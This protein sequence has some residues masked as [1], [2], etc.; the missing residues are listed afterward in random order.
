MKKMLAMV[1]TVCL[2]ATMIV[3]CGNTEETASTETTASVQTTETESATSTEKIE[4]EDWEEEPVEVTWMMW[5]VGGQHSE[6]GVQAV[7][8]A[9]NEITLE[10]I[11][12]K[13]NLEMLDM[14]TYMTQMP[15][16][17][18]AGDKIDLITTF[19]AASGRY[20]TMVNN[21]QLLPLDDLLEVY[22]QDMLA[23]MP[24]DYCNATTF[25]GSVY[26]VPI[27]TDNTSDLYW[28]CKEPYLEE[29]GMSIEDIKN[30]EDMGEVFEKLHE[31][32]PEL[33][34]LTGAGQSLIG[35]AGTLF[36]GTNY[37]PMGTNFL[38]VEQDENG[39]YIVKNLFETENYKK[40]IEVLNDWYAKGYVDKDA[41]MNETPEPDN[42]T[43]F[44]WF[45]AGNKTRTHRGEEGYSDK[46][47]V[48][49]KLTDGLIGTSNMTIMTMA[50]PV[51]ATEPEAA[52]KLMNLCYTNSELKMLVSYGIEG[53][54]YT[55]AE[56]GGVVV[57][58]ENTSYQVNTIGTF[59]N[60]LLC[61]PTEANVAMDYDMRKI[62]QSALLYSPLLGFTINNDAVA[63][64]FG[65][66]SA[67][68]EE[69]KATVECGMASEENY[70]EMID[71][72]YANGLQIYID[73]VQRQLDAWMAH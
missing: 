21:G 8:D 58:Q 52:A 32:H 14:G 48:R 4:T 17:I 43:W 34:L 41:M 53:E 28:I 38:T 19:P 56:N 5:N 30:F 15:I 2:M 45:L 24:Q 16:Q 39:N 51:S 44:S 40:C 20:E 12:V 69:Y 55:I 63:N 72:M 65:A 25:N 18:T 23:V 54:N 50:I 27:L 66:V 33:K 11:N 3:A 35:S 46:P 37:D 49:V 60:A 71:K 29:I 31:L 13:V 22:G 73:E 6:G 36:T 68:M 47:L 62:D 61:T 7:E 26:A 59:G 42:P 57:N 67:V 1:L 10:K 70:Q 9:L 64:E